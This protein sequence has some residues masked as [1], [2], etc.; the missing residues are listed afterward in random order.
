MSSRLPIGPVMA[1]KNRNTT[2][3]N[4]VKTPRPKLRTTRSSGQLKR[5]RLH[6]TN[7]GAAETTTD[8]RQ[9]KATTCYP[10]RREGW[11]AEEGKG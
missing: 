5:M 8:D 11:G 4:M 3:Q 9:A 6:H 10:K 1:R 2:S 7:S